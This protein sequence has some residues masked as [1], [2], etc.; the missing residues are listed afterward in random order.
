MTYGWAGP[1]VCSPRLPLPNSGTARSA[2]S[3]CR[4]RKGRQAIR[5]TGRRK[6][7]TAA[8]PRAGVRSLRFCERIPRGFPSR[9]RTAPGS[10]APDP[11]SPA[12][13]RPPRTRVRPEGLSARPTGGPAPRGPRGR[14]RAPARER[15][16]GGPGRPDRVSEPAAPAR[17]PGPHLRKHPYGW[18]SG[19]GRPRRERCGAAPDA[20]GNGPPGH[21]AGPVAGARGRGSRS[22]PPDRIPR[23]PP[24]PCDSP[25][26][27]A[28]FLRTCAPRPVSQRSPGPAC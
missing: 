19:R 2:R 10:S 5:H 22:R 28:R 27:S 18:S 23:T 6:G 13:I 11:N 16:A 4:H 8:C 20:P 1:A 15:R 26:T 3:P 7:G 12:D 9:F 21:A 24:T 14:P 25:H 17:S